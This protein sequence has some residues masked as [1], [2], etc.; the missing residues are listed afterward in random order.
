[1]NPRKNVLIVLD[2]AVWAQPGLG[3]A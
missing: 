3:A 2:E 1:V